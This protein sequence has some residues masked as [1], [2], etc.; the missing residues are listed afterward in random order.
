MIEQHYA[1]IIENMLALRLFR[2]GFL[3]SFWVRLILASLLLL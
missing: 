3:A 1:I 2:H